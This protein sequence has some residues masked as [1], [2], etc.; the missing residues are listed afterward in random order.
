MNSCRISA[1]VHEF[2]D[3]CIQKLQQWNENPKLLWTEIAKCIH[4]EENG[5]FLEKIRKY[6]S[7]AIEKMLEIFGQFNSWPLKFAAFANPKL[8]K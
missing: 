5:E 2:H 3:E 6:T 4:L 7:G 8:G 1:I